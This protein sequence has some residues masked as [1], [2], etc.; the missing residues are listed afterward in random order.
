M[1]HDNPQSEKI[2]ELMNKDTIIMPGVFDPLTAKLAEQAGFKTL[3]IS[4]A[5]LTASRGMPDN[6]SIYHYKKNNDGKNIFKPRKYLE[7]VKDII[8]ATNLP[9]IV[10]IDTGF[11]SFINLENAVRILDQAG[12]AGV[13]IEDQEFPKRC[14]HL[15]GKNIVSTAEMS[16]RIKAARYACSSD[17]FLIV[18]RTDAYAIAGFQETISRSATYRNSGAD[19]IFPEALTTKKDF[20]LFS[21][22]VAP[23]LLANM[24]EF[25]KTP[26]LT[27]REF[28]E[29]GYSI[30]I[31]PASILRIAM[32][33]MKDFLR[34]LNNAG[35]QKDYI[36]KMQTRQELYDL[37]DYKP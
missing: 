37:I 33:A 25:G 3:Y 15:K 22:K 27:A 11:G 10:D 34:H 19:I 29:M 14:G 8:K 4:G 36:D 32:K 26:Y 18:A 28:K 9:V 12:A 23:P 16:E 7:L 20:T 5:A 17:N 30:V 13:Q 21:R 35:T 31:F 24:T 1:K 6:G 2:I